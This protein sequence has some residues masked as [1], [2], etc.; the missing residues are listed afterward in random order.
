MPVMPRVLDVFARFL[1]LGLSAFGGP[2]AHLGYFRREF[3]TRAGWLEDAAFT[4]IVALCSVLPGPTS[5]QVGILIGAR[6]AGRLGAAAAWLGFTAPSALALACVGGIFRFFQTAPRRIAY[7]PDPGVAHR[8]LITHAAADAALLSL[9]LV[10]AAVVLLAVAALARAIVVDAFTAIVAVLCFAAALGALT[11]APSWTWVAIALGALAGV[12]FAKPSTPPGTPALA[13]VSP[14]SGI[15]AAIGLAGGL[16]VLPLFAHGGYLALFTTTFR[17]GALV[18]GGGH[19]V[20]GFLSALIG[21]PGVDEATFSR[22]YGIVQTVPG[23]LF[24][25]ASLLGAADTGVP[26]PWIGALV[27]TIGIFAPSFLILPAALAGWTTVRHAPRAGAVLTG[28]NASVVG[29]LGAT[30]VN[31]ICTTLGARLYG[32]D[33]AIGVL[34]FAL[35]T[36]ARMPAWLVVIVCAAASAAY[37]A[38]AV[39][40]GFPAAL[41]FA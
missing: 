37:Q 40:D 2:V 23:P 1:R 38:V 12:T 32:A 15:I 21:S 25:F 22:G 29:L 18:F 7:A 6:R 17:A 24:T 27:A 31:P 8:L 4:E 13:P 5:S 34:A 28:A 35:L 9:R 26:N 14:R 30:F 3:V 36:R 20:L 33:L 19:V 39:A 10:A 41:R 16:V 11:V